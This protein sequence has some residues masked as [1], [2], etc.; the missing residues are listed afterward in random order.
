LPPLLL[1]VP[2]VDASPL[3]VPPVDAS[4]L[5]LLDPPSS[6]LEPPL[7]PLDV[8][9]PD[10]L[11]SVVSSSPGSVPNTDAPGGKK[12]SEVSAPLQPSTMAMPKNEVAHTSGAFIMGDHNER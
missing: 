8:D 9:G 12:S 4:A 7:L 3:D 6:A 1:D 5:E 2:P 11:A 10:T